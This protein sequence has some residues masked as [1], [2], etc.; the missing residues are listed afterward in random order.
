MQRLKTA[1]GRRVVVVVTDGRD[2]NAASTAAGSA[3]TWDMV[4]SAARA[5]D[6]TVYAIGL[7]TRVERGRLQQLADL[8]GGEA[9][10]TNDLASLDAEYRRV[11]EDLHRRYVLGYSSTN[12]TRDGAWRTVELHGANGLRLRSRG[13]Y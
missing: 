7:G 3:A 13:G 6:V 2:E 8:T 11:V 9:Y 5:S 12:A 10:F 1:A 4:I